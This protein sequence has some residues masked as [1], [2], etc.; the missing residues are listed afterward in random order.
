[1]VIKAIRV[2][3]TKLI[4]AV[5]NFVRAVL[6]AVGVGNGPRDTLEALAT[7]RLI[8]RRSEHL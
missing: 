4:E 3:V 8:H 5:G 1:M 6:L 2:D 7:E